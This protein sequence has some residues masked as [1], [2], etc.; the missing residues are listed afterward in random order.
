MTMVDRLKDSASTQWYDLVN[1]PFVLGIGE[2][3]VLHRQFSYF[4]IQDAL[5][6]GDFLSTLAVAASRTPRRDWAE[7]LLRHAQN[8]TIVETALHA[9]LLPSFGVSADH[10]A[11]AKQGLVTAA[12]ADHLVRTAWSRT[13]SQ[14]MAAIL[15]CYLSYHEIGLHLQKHY[16]SPDPL[17][18]QWIDTYA[19]SDYGRAVEEL[20]E[21]VNKMAINEEE[22]PQLQQVFERSV[23]YEA[24]FWSQAAAEGHLLD[25]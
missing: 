11:D 25:S 1:H 10:L 5:Y 21:M 20:L 4:L 7:T 17:Y 15:P 22:F 24:L 19:G 3:T 8:V 23:N 9:S 6:L 16:H 18:R 14:T 12:Y 13:W 2:G